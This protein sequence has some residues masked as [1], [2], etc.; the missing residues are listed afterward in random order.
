MADVPLIDG[1]AG[2]AGEGA[3][4]VVED[5]SVDASGAVVDSWAETE[6]AAA[7]A[8]VAGATRRVGVSCRGTD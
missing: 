3:G 5:H 2:R 1:V 6:G 8:K 4:E 7:V